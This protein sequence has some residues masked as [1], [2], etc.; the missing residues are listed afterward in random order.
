MGC[1]VLMP[2]LKYYKVLRWPPMSALVTLHCGDTTVAQRPPRKRIALSMRKDGGAEV[3]QPK[4]A[5]KPKPA[6]Y[7]QTHATAKPASNSQ[8]ALGSAL[9]AALKGQGDR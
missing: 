9:A 3:A 5:A 2:A 1:F 6:K 4:A 7:K 8:G